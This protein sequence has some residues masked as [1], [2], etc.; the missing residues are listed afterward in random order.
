ML[1]KIFHFFTDNYQSKN[2]KELKEMV[3]HY[4]VISFDVFD[5]LIKRDIPQPKDMYTLLEREFAIK[6]F[7]KMRA[8]AENQAYR[9]SAN[10]E[11]SLDEIYSCFE[12]C[13]FDTQL[14]KD[15]E[16][17]LEIALACPNLLILGIYNYS[18]ANKTVILV[19][20]MYLDKQTIEAMLQKC[21]IV[22]YQKLYLSSEIGKRKSNGDLY[23][24]VLQDLAP[25]HDQK[26]LH[27]GNSFKDD[28]WMAKKSGIDAVKISTF[29]E[30]TQKHYSYSHCSDKFCASLL[31]TFLNNHTN[32]KNEWQS[33]GYERLGSL[34]YG[35][36]VWLLREMKAAKIDR[37][38]FCS[39]DGYIIR[40]A[41]QA[42]GYD[43]IIPSRYFEVSRRS[44]R[45][46]LF[47]QN[48][49][50]EDVVNLL[51]YSPLYKTMTQIFDNLGLRADDYEDIIPQYGFDKTTPIKMTSLVHDNRFK[52]L[53][54]HIEN[55]VVKNAEEERLA[56]IHYL[57]QVDFTNSRVAIVDIGWGGSIQKYLCQTMEMLNVKH[58]IWGYYVALDKRA[59]VV[60]RE[61]K[62]RAKGYLIDHRAFPQTKM[63][64]RPLCVFLELFFLHLAGS[65]RRYHYVEGK[66]AVEYY[67]SE[68]VV[69][70]TI[71]PELKYISDIQDSAIKFVR[72]F[73]ISPLAT[74][75]GVDKNVMFTNLCNAASKPSIHDVNMFYHFYAL[76]G[77]VIKYFADA[78]SF[79]YYV[80]HPRQLKKDFLLSAWKTGFLKRLIW[81]PLPYTSIC[82]MFFKLQYRYSVDKKESSNT[83]KG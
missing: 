28:F 69:S 34:L 71:Y 25:I 22:G 24:F 63:T 40:Q 3:K 18:I 44:L 33:F 42:L 55:D 51:E 21:G 53:Y 78:K 73:A 62:Y 79:W 35:F 13:N 26:I 50:I 16:R 5:T 48:M 66:T 54:R 77:D 2:L 20:D 9:K 81:L 12:K 82:D 29:Y 31:N 30:R 57:Q 36:S 38:L 17:Q 27:I 11:V 52:K 23:E 56:L 14:V 15:R 58:N 45:V 4:D 59:K 10:A 6:N 32:G 1:K 64:L 60:L 76:D 68:Y 65:V 39:R 37:V 75:V 80:F 49:S 67:P 74:F 72:D 70:D 19:S 47:H 41:Y 8:E 61:K 83:N 7:A 43:K 46:P